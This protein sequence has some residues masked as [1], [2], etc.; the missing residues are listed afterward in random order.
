MIKETRGPRQSIGAVGVRGGEQSLV[1]TKGRPS[2]AAEAV[3]G[4]RVHHV[5]VRAL[6]RHPWIR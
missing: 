2:T 1:P 3:G 6:R 4:V 5:V